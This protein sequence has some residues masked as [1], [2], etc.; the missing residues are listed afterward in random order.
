MMRDEYAVQVGQLLHL[1]FQVV[2]LPCQQS[3][4]ARHP[5]RLRTEL[6]QFAGESLHELLLISQ[7]LLDSLQGRK[8]PL[9]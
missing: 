5:A 6:C 9:C 4:I 8:L 7:L 1:V 3:Q 2:H